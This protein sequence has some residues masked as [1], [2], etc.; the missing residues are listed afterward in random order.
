MNNPILRI[1]VERMTHCIRSM[2]DEH[3][4]NADGAIKQALGDFEKRCDD[5]I[6]T[7]ALREIEII[8][9]EEVA[10]FFRFGKGREA[11]KAAVAKL[12]DGRG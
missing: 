7:T 1:E 2:L 4:F 6:A 12:L 3:V 11:L 5:Y 8:V 9:S 10:Q